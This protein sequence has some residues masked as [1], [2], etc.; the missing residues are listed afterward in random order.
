MTILAHS[1]RFLVLV[2]L[3]LNGT[4]AHGLQGSAT[5]RSHAPVA[6]AGSPSCHTNTDHVMPPSKR[7]KVA[8]PTLITMLHP[9]INAAA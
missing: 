3:I 5:S 2:A 1:L 9:H 6:K 8:I 4:G 7:R